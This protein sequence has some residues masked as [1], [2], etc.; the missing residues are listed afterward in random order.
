MAHAAFFLCCVILFSLV[1]AQSGLNLV[2]ETVY[3]SS[4]EVELGG[5]VVRANH[6]LGSRSIKNS[7]V[8]LLNRVTK[9]EEDRW[10]SMF[11]HFSFF[12]PMLIL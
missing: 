3:S 1:W 2:A 5:R 7:Y 11:D 9:S 8:M 12:S 10:G 6:A 4:W